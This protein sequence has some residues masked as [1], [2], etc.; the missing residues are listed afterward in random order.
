MLN[1]QRRKQCGPKKIK[2]DMVEAIMIHIK[3]CKMQEINGC[4]TGEI[5]MMMPKLGLNLLTNLRM[6]KKLKCGNIK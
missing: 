5:D 3:L 1:G 4:M 6:I 2:E